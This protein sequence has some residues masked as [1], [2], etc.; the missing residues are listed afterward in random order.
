MEY[1]VFQV[2]SVPEGESPILNLVRKTRVALPPMDE[3]NGKQTGGWVSIDVQKVIA[4][5]FRWPEENYGI[6]VHAVH[7][8]T[9]SKS[10]SSPYIINDSVTADGSL[11]SVDN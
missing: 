4:D 2:V 10:S 1:I 6:V 11:V 9:N 8:D 7:A 3:K 5:W